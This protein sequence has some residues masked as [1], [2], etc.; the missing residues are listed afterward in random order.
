MS[1]VRLQTLNVHFLTFLLSVFPDGGTLFSNNQP[2]F[3]NNPR[4]LK[5]LNYRSKKIEKL[6]KING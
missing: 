1:H 3:S 5:Y 2:L 6:L 4:L